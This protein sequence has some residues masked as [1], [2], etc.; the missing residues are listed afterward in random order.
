VEVVGELVVED[1]GTD[2]QQLRR[3]VSSASQ[4]LDHARADHWLTANSVNA[5]EMASPRRRGGVHP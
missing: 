1:S 3:P 2:L 5:V 4:F